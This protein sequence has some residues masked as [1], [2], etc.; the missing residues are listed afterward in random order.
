MSSYLSSLLPVVL[1]SYNSSKSLNTTQQQ[2]DL[3]KVCQ[4]FR[5]TSLRELLVQLCSLE[6]DTY[7]QPFNVSTNNNVSHFQCISEEECFFN[8]VMRLACGVS[9]I[10]VL[11]RPG[12]DTLGQISWLDVLW[13]IQEDF[14][15]LSKLLPKGS[16]L[17]NI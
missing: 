5:K 9:A 14:S 6:G 4:V 16:L 15:L 2:Q 8:V 1:E 13:W 3:T 10:A 12:M 7:K 17:I 11:G